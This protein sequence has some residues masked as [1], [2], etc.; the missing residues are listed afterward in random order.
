MNIGELRSFLKSVPRD[1]YVTGWEERRALEAIAHYFLRHVPDRYPQLEKFIGQLSIGI[2]MQLDPEA[3][4]P[5]IEDLDEVSFNKIAW[6]QNYIFTTGEWLQAISRLKLL[7]QFTDDHYLFDETFMAAQMQAIVDKIDPSSDEHQVNLN[8][9]TDLLV[10][11]TE[12]TGRTLQK[13]D[14]GD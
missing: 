12:W 8:L 9:L 13:D 1:R 6:D 10:E 5:N 3:M 11:M 4:W 14:E 2:I 7:R